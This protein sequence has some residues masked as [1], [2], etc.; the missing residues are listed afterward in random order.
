MKPRRRTVRMEVP[1][2][3]TL[4]RLSGGPPP[5]PLARERRSLEVYRDVHFDTAGGELGRKGAVVR[6][7]HHQDG[8]RTLMIDIREPGEGGPPLRHRASADVTESD[9]EAVFAGDSKPARLLRALVDPRRLDVAFE[10]ETMRQ[11]RTGRTDEGEGPRIELAYDTLTVRRGSLSGSLWEILITAPDSAGIGAVIR[12]LEDEPGVRIT[13]SEPARRARE[14]LDD[15]EIVALE[16]EVRAARE[17]A[18]AAVRADRIALIRSEDGLRIPAGDGSGEMA[19][20]RVLDR[21]LSGQGG[22]VRLLGTNAG[23]PGRPALEVWL[24]EDAVPEPAPD[25]VVWLSLSEILGTVGSAGLRH[26]R[27][28]AALEVVARSDLGGETPTATR[29]P[30]GAGAEAL[31]LA[32]PA[33]PSLDLPDKDLPPGHLLNAELSRMAFDERMLVYAE[34]EE[35]PLLERVRFLAM[36]GGR[37]DDFFMTRVAGFKDELT[38]GGRRETLD[39][40]TAQEQLD[41]IAIRARQIT[42]RAQRLLHDRLIPALAE[43]GIRILRWAELEDD[44]RAFLLDHFATDAEAVLT[45]LA[46]DASHPFPHIRNLRPAIA[47]VVR[48][49]DADRGHFTAIELPGELPRF[50]PLP[51]G[52]RF[53]PLEELLVARLPELFSGLEVQSAHLFRITRSAKTQ[54]DETLIG[55]VLQMVEEDVARRPFRAP[56]RLEVEASMPFALRD[57]I[58]REVRY[59]GSGEV[60]RLGPQDLY[61]I[62]GLIDL[63]TLAELASVPGHD[64]LRFQPMERKDPFDHDRSI[65]EILRERDRLVHFPYEAFE[66]TAARFI[67]EAAEDPDVVSLKVT[68]YRTDASSAVVKALSRARQL[69][70]DAVALIEIKASFDEQRNIAWARSLTAAGIHV[71]FSPLKYKVH[72]KAGLVVR[73]EGDGLARYCYIGTGNLNNRTARSYTDVAL[74]TA[75]QEIGEEVQAVF[76]ILTGYSAPSEFTHLLVSPFNMRRRLLERIERE[77]EHARAGRGGSLRGQLNGLADRRTIA[78]LYEASQ[79]G[80]R[81][82]L[83]AREICALRPGVPGLSE[84]IR[85]ISV[86]GRLLQHA[87]IFEFGNGGDPE[88]IIGSADWRP[89]NLSRR[90]EVAVPVREPECRARLKQI[91]DDLLSDPSAWELRPDGSHVRSDDRVG[92]AAALGDRALPPAARAIGG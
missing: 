60:V 47:A 21:R 71:V 67:A 48:L 56:V 78:K 6:L 5:V 36:F 83:A 18:V 2:G 8:R 40:L 37:H 57:L 7:R 63:A 30:E 23:G 66:T 13:L 27:T 32:L 62:D 45:P 85:I 69:G 88:Y 81:I 33:P 82:E 25:G 22:R 46:A 38:L 68:L 52:N 31:E 42:A 79:A 61:V 43:E 44:E 29:D 14:F 58:L 77:I 89:R 20:R 73:R 91:L 4:D 1:S 28:L 92:G 53:V 75:D 12:A 15:A 9:A 16:R 39:G 90:V 65:F 24:A 64:D 87:R 19:C 72:A 10:I 51:D 3:E 80:V 50:L 17:V 49:P 59:E 55:D 54:L 84:N 41:L 34:S 86:L 11:I 26:R 35:A 76:N 74:L 70:K